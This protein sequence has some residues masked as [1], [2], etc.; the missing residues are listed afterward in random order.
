M[1][2]AHQLPEPWGERLAEAAAT[3]DPFERRKAIE[4]V[5]RRLRLHHPEVFRSER[6]PYRTASEIFKHMNRKI[7]K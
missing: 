3:S 7:E 5:I 6:E 2:I 4:D 1:D